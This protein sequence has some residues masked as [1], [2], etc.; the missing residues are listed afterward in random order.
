MT[1][2]PL[3]SLTFK[4]PAM[5]CAAEEQL[6]RLHLAEVAEIKR[7]AFDLSQ[8]TVVVT[9]SG[10]AT[11]IEQRLRGLNLGASLVAREP[12]EDIPLET[13]DTRQRQLLIVVLLINFGLF[14]LE[15]VMGLIANSMGLIADAL[16]MLADALVYGLSLYAVGQA[17]VRKQQVA[18]LSGY[19]QFALAIFGLIEVVRRF[20]G[21]GDEPSFTLMIV[22]SLI[23]LAGN[24]ASLLVLQ[25]TQSQEVHMKASWIFTSNDVIVNISVIVAGVL[26][27]MTGSKLP[28]LL[29]G[30]AVF[31]LVAQGAFRILNLSK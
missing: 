4:V 24:V 11:A 13:T 27:F 20:I 22:I 8:R 12:V 1:Q 18:R 29:V 30:A 21:T 9:H 19:F 17:M 2:P 28:D 26:V 15:L 23:A 7:L 3:E 6:V 14:V 25:R 16:D 10:N 31:G 5:D